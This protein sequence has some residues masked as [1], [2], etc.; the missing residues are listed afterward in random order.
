[1]KKPKSIIIIAREWHDKINGNSYFSA[2]VYVD[3]YLYARLPFQYGYGDCYIDVARDTMVQRGRLP[4][5]P[6]YRYGM[7]QLWQYCQDNDI[8]LHSEKVRVARQRDAKN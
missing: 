2:T 8:A 6:V 3:D 1:M 7:Q 5:V 4:K